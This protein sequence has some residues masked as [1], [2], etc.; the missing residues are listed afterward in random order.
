MRTKSTFCNVL[1][2]KNGD[3]P[4]ANVNHA[5]ASIQPRSFS[6]DAG[7]T[8][9][10][11]SIILAVVTFLGN[12]LF[13]VVLYKVPSLHPPTK[14]LF[15]CL[16][17]TDLCVVLI[18]QPLGVISRYFTSILEKNDNTLHYKNILGHVNLA[19]TLAFCVVSILTSTAISVD[20]LL[21]LL[22]GLR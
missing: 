8:S 9:F 20:R 12:V 6:A 15:G 4:D 7:A 18:S 3:G 14:L 2:L 21:A 17:V 16:A 19:S 1:T 11:M 22:L 10:A 13:L 5:S